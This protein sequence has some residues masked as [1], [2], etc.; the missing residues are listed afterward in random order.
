VGRISLFVA[1]L[2]AAVAFTAVATSASSPSVTKQALSLF[3][4]NGEQHGLNGFN[5]QRPPRAGD[6]TA[7]T[8]VLFKWDAGRRGARIGHAELIITSKTDLGPR[9]AVGLLVAQMFLAGGS[10]FV[11]GYTRF[12]GAEKPSSFPILG[13]TGSYATASGY[14][15]SRPLG[16]GRT[17]LDLHLA[18]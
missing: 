18:R 3:A 12:G 11:E 17:K 4:V 1:I 7:R 10:L 16:Q 15:I 5:F 8:D 14:V 9:G 6:Q 13:G 2:V